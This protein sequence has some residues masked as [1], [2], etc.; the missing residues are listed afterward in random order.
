[1]Q[2]DSPSAIAADLPPDRPLTPRQIGDHFRRHLPIT[3]EAV[4]RYREAAAERRGQVAEVGAER[5]VSALMFTRRLM[6]IVHARL[7]RGEVV[8]TVADGLRAAAVLAPLE[9]HEAG[10]DHLPRDEVGTAF[11]AYLAAVRQHTQPDQFARIAADIK[12]DPVLL[13]LW[14]GRANNDASDE[15]RAS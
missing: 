11:M 15:A 5:E 12:G 7:A 8:P 10:S 2:G 3:D 13:S 4:A 14:R 9:D 1:M 6:L